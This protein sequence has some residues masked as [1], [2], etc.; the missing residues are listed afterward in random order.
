MAISTEP[1]PASVSLPDPS[2]PESYP[3]LLALAGTTDEEWLLN[4]ETNPVHAAL[5]EAGL[6]RDKRVGAL[7][8]E[9]HYLRSSNPPRG[10][11]PKLG[12]EEDYWSGCAMNSP[13]SDETQLRARLTM[14]RAESSTLASL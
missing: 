2:L 8:R 12:S 7:L 14:L 1:T 9:M 13:G 10:F 11:D 3:K 4:P 6:Q 5:L